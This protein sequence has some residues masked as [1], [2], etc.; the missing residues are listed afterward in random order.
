M[1]TAVIPT[2][3]IEELKSFFKKNRKPDLI[4]SYLFFLEKKH[5][6]NPVIFLKEKR[7]YKSKE[8]LIHF[9]EKQGKLWRETEIKIQIGEPEVNT[10]TKKIY[11][12]PFSGKVFGDNT[13]ANP[14]DAIYDWVSTCRENTERVDG[15]RVKRFFVSEDPE[16]IKNYIKPQKVAL[17]KTVFSSAVTGKLFANKQTVVEDFVQHMLKSI[18]LAEVPSQ[19]RYEIQEDFLKF[20]EEH[21]KETQISSFVEAMS[22]Y[23]EFSKYVASWLEEGEQEDAAEG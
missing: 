12:C 5:H 15:Q 16:V 21:L 19:N 11:I 1:T 22:Q 7:I 23:P 20:I 17:K 18:P 9:L 14:Q 2:T 4:T 8:E 13:H 10:H 6:L 3:L